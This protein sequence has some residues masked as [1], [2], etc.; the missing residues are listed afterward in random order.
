MSSGPQ[1]DLAE[2][3]HLHVTL[4]TYEYELRNVRSTFELTCTNPLAGGES[5]RAVIQVFTELVAARA[6]VLD[7]ISLSISTARMQSNLSHF[8]DNL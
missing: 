6:R 5:F 4:R 7:S 3:L 2:D 8:W 1:S